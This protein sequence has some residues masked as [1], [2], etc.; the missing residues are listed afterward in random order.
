[1]ASSRRERRVLGLEPA[2][3]TDVPASYHTAQGSCSNLL[4]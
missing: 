1:M 3:R 4:Q 2:G